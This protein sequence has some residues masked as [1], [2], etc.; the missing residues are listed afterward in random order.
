MTSGNAK[1]NG[2]S[3]VNNGHRGKYNNT[4]APGHWKSLVP[5]TIYFYYFTKRNNKY[6]NEFYFVHDA[7]APITESQLKNK[8]IS[9]LVDNATGPKNNPPPSNEKFGTKPWKRISW[10]VVAVKDVE[11]ATGRA[12]EIKWKETST[13]EKENHSFFDGGDRI[14]TLDGGGKVGVIWTWNH[15]RNADGELLEE[16]EQNDFH[17]H[18]IREGEAVV[19]E[20]DES[21]TNTGPVV[22]PPP[23]VVVTGDAGHGKDKEGTGRA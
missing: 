2:S 3:S 16:N 22:K 6:D 12:A 23:S 19:V 7:D 1:G 5:H 14:V 9:H 21:G 4:N 8:W 15:F 18:F 17:F 20:I 11:I 10:L 13:T